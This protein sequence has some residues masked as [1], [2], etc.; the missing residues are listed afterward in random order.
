M[1]S[2]DFDQISSSQRLLRTLQKARVKLEAMETAKNDPI[3]I[4]GMSCRFPGE[5]NNPQDF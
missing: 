5:A 4:I 3:A 1:N 2:K